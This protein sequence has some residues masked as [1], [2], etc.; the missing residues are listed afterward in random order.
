MVFISPL[1]GYILSAALNNWLHHT[2]GQRGIAM[3]AGGCHL[4]AYIIIAAHPPYV[5]IIL[6]FI[7]AGL[8][9]GLAD[10]A[11]NAYI[12]NRANPSELLGL[13]HACY[14][15]GGVFSPSV[16]TAMITEEGL[17]L[18]WYNY[19]YILVRKI[20]RTLGNLC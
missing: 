13:M 20:A 19:Y 8:S 7:L 2:I 17:G 15:A 3:L 12:G 11:W 10:A 6:A 14:G 18:P 16:S 4:S 9:N 5:V 1:V